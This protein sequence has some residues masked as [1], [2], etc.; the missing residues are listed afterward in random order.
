MLGVFW[1]A[2]VPSVSAQGINDRANFKNLYMALITLFRVVTGDT[3]APLMFDCTVDPS[4]VRSVTSTAMS[5]G[6]FGSLALLTYLSIS[7]LSAII[8]LEGLNSYFQTVP[9][10]RHS[11]PICP[12]I[13]Q[14]TSRRS[15]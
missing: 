4:G 13:A 5:V 11:M 7:L 8:L 10:C 12:A 6:F 14:Q 15:Q 9:H 3:W 2:S 1:F